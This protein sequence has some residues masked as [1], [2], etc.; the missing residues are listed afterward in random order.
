MKGDNGK[1]CVGH[2]IP[3]SV[4]MTLRSSLAS[5]ARKLI[6]VMSQATSTPSAEMTSESYASATAASLPPEMK[7]NTASTSR[8]QSTVHPPDA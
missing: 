8:N 5:T 2:A 1:H 3:M 4:K 7:S 6:P